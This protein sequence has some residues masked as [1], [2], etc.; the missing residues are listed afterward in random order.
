[1]K[2]TPRVS[3]AYLLVAAT[4]LILA[5]LLTACAPSTPPAEEAA[6]T[7]EAAAPAEETAAPAEEEAAPAEEEAAPAEEEVFDIVLSNNF[8]GNQWRLEMQNIA[9]AMA[10]N[11]EPYAGNVNFRIVVAEGDPTAQIQ[12]LEAIIATEPDA[13]LL[14]AA[15]PTA[16]NPVLQEACDK[17]IIVIS[18]DQTVTEPCTYR[19]REQNEE[20]YLAN[21]EWLVKSIG[22][23]GNILQDLGLP[24]QPLSQISNGVLEE[25]YGQYPGINIVGTFEGN[26][27]PGPSQQAVAN[28]LATGMEIDAVY[29]LAGSDGIIQAYV[30]AGAPQDL[31]FVPIVNTGDI[32]VRTLELIREY[33]GTSLE[34]QF[35]DNPPTF[36]GYALEVAWRVLHDMDPVNEEWGMTLGNDPKEIF[37]PLRVY[38]TNGVTTSS[39]AEVL[40]VDDLMHFLDEGLPPDTQLPYSIPQS[41]VTKEQ[42]FGE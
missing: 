33:E 9:K 35:A 18:F 6:P 37:L 15:S 13:I 25:V 32:A 12:S 24:G 28:A 14:D 23:E 17:G 39:S 10:E 34:V 16:L 19:V 8:V 1:M 40:P 11:N 20:L 29:N 5:L 41:P 2:T 27:A 26:Y 4:M 7:E 38:N 22:E 21:G 30:Q 42:V 31:D 36:G 3:Q